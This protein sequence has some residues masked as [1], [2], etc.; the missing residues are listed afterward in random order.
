MPLPSKYKELKIGDT[1]LVYVP[2]LTEGFL[3]KEPYRTT[4]ASPVKEDEDG[5]Y[6]EATLHGEP[7]PISFNQVSQYWEVSK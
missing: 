3:S 6:A 5:M 2:R 4:L 7:T 1:I